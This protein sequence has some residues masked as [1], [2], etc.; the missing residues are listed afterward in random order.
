MT[1]SSNFPTTVGAYDMTYSG[2]DAFVSKLNTNL[3]NLTASTFLGV[4][5][6]RVYVTG[7]TNSADFP[8][9]AGAINTTFNGGSSD[10]FVSKFNPTLSNLIASTFLGGSADE[11]GYKIAAHA[12]RL[13]VTGYTGSADFPTTA[14]AYDTTFNGWRDAIVLKLHPNLTTLHASTFVGGTISTDYGND[15]GISA[16]GIPYITGHTGSADFPTTAGASDTTHNGG[17]DAF[18]SRLSTNLSSILASTFHGGSGNDYGMGITLGNS[19]GGIG[20]GG[21]IV[22]DTSSLN[23]PVTAGVYNGGL[24]DGFISKLDRFL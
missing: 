2:S 17:V 11:S 12:G 23:F 4:Y 22:G 9:T 3:S 20:V 6:G 10:L 24:T 15:I 1:S 14:G 5:A 21:F 19:T 13:Y 18:V 8:T 16:S 7:Y